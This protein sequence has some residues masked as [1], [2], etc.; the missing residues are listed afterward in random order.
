MGGRAI[1]RSSCCV[2][3]CSA[4]VPT[5]CSSRSPTSRKLPCAP[6]PSSTGSSL[7]LA[8][9]PH[10]VPRSP[11][12]CVHAHHL[13]A[14]ALLHHARCTVPPPPHVHFL[15]PELEPGGNNCITAAAPVPPAQ[16]P[17]PQHGACQIWALKFLSVIKCL[18][19]KCDCIGESSKSFSLNHWL[20]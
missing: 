10:D 13:G 20:N 19:K 7:W 11:P 3:P 12:H 5:S 17:H 4:S 8:H 6:C 16:H 14:H 2:P 18:F 9:P 1:A 15:G